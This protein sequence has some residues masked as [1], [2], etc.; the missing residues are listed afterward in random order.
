MN[1]I[2]TSNIKLYPDQALAALQ[3]L[4][5]LLESTGRDAEVIEAMHLVPGNRALF[6]GTLEGRDVVF[7]LPLDES[8]RLSFA[9]EWAE[10]SRAHAYMSNPPN[11]VVDPVEFDP[12]TG[13][14]VISYIPGTPLFTH[15]RRAEPDA[16]LPLIARAANWLAIYTRPTVADEKLNYRTWF[17]KACNAADAQPHTSLREIEARIMR[18]MKRLGRRLH[19]TDCRTAIS[20]GDF[21]LNNLILNGE[22]LVGIDTGGSSRMP[23]YKDIARAL[24]HMARRAEPYSANRHF[25]V[26]AASFNAFAAAFELTAI[27][28][29][30]YLPFMIAFETLIKVEH[31]EMPEDRLAKAET[32]AH[33]LF[34][35]L[36]QIT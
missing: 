14:L 34:R 20:H 19:Q 3:T 12:D 23:I 33:A 28:R 27:E 6:R 30:A 36:R 35:D 25:G 17:D 22:T 11:C 2:T 4:E 10:L 32:M 1:V 7:R 13:L 29:E 9:K 24:T 8:I 21:H 5:S 26:D 15:L 18:R 31:P 16:R